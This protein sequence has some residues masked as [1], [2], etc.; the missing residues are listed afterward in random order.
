MLELKNVYKIYNC[1][2][3]N[4]TEALNNV[5]ISF[6]KN[7]FVS[8]LGPSGCGK[9]T[10]LNLIAGLDKATSGEIFIDGCRY[11]SLNCKKWNSYRCSHIGIVF[12][13]YNLIP[14]ESVIGNVEL[15]LSIKGLKHQ[16]SKKMALQALELV[17]LKNIAYKRANEIS[18]GQAQRVAIARA[19]VNNPD[20]ILADEPTGALD[21]DN[22]RQIMDLLKKLAFDHLVILVTHNSL[23]A[24]EYS[25][26][27][28]KMNEGMIVSDS[29]PYEIKELDNNL[30]L[31]KVR[32]KLVNALILSIKNL[33]LKRRRTIMTIIANSLVMASIALC[34]CL[35]ANVNDYVLDVQNNLISSQPIEITNDAVDYLK[36]L[37]DISIEDKADIFKKSGN[38]SVFEM[39]KRINNLYKDL[40][41]SVNVKNEL[42]DDYVN[43][44]KCMNTSPTTGILYTTGMDLTYSMYTNYNDDNGQ[45][46]RSIECIRKIYQNILSQTEL[47]AISSFI[48]NYST[49]FMELVDNYDYINNDYN[50]VGGRMPQNKNEIVLVLDNNSTATD[51]LLATLGFYTQNEFINVVNSVIN[52]NE[53][54]KSS[55]SYDEILGHEFYWM[56]NDSIFK[57]NFNEYTNKIDALQPFFYTPSLDN[58]T[59]S[60]KLRVVG[61]LEPKSSGAIRSGFYYTKELSNYIYEANKNSKIIKF[62]EMAFESNDYPYIKYNTIYSGRI[63]INNLNLDV[64]ITYKYNYSYNNTMYNDVVG[65]CGGDML[66]GIVSAASSTL[67]GSDLI[68][69]ASLSLHQLGGSDKINKIIIYSSDITQRNKI[70]SYLNNWNSENDIYVNDRLI[71]RGDRLN[72]NIND[73]SILIM[74]IINEIKDIIDISL[75]IFCAICLIISGIMIFIV[76]YISVLD[77]T[78][79]IGILRTLGANKFKISSLFI[80]ENIIIGL[81]S[82]IFAVIG[83]LI[84]LII[85]KPLILNNYGIT[86]SF[87]S[88]GYYLLIIISSIAIIVIS[89]LIPTIESIAVTPAKSLRSE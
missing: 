29:N 27:I 75:I 5:S 47:K 23:L 8:V 70:T 16:E 9:T 44:V 77:R 11:S 56:N 67:I 87:L 31:K 45:A 52:D 18:G 61:I 46:I 78:K 85:V 21:D 28:V 24:N 7:E 37:N 19:L 42:T 89:G 53:D 6:R 80:F 39:T 54:Y 12:Q 65:Y 66:T 3:K 43:Y 20:I 88:I 62:L 14:Q 71:K 69:L 15:A 30:A 74:S 63:P 48:S 38:V 1:K 59:N 83:T 84:T 72:V 26:R 55:F 76:T 13:S 35:K 32:F 58:T 22:S 33:V 4:K 60:L 25:D 36:I 40:N 34:F 2:K 51:L 82:G 10:L 73:S 17:G 64:G 57:E 86:I 81:I 79:E 50:V 41:D 68:N 49:S